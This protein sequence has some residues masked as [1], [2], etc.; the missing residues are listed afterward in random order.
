MTVESLI[1]RLDG[2]V[3]NDTI[4][5]PTD[6]YMV[7]GIKPRIV[8]VP[9]DL[10]ELR[11]IMQLVNEYKASV[12]P[13]IRGTKLFIGNIPKSYDAALDLGRVA[14][15]VKADPEE[16][17]A[18]IGVSV[19]FMDAQNEL[20]RVG[21]R[22]PMDPLLSSISSIG[23][24]MALNLY[25][26]MAHRLLT[27]R[28]LVLRVRA[29][30]PGGHVVKWGT[31]MIKDV[32]GYNLKRV[33]IGSMG[34]LGVIYEVN[35]RLLAVPEVEAVVSIR[36][37]MDLRS[38][39]RFMGM[40]YISINGMTYIRL[41]GVKEEVEYRISSIKGEVYYGRE[42]YEL[43][44]RVTS[45]DELFDN[46]PVILKIITPPAQLGNIIGL[47]N[48]YLVTLPM[49]GIAYVGVSSID[50]KTISNVRE[51]ATKVGGYVVVLKAPLDIKRGI[52]VWGVTTNVDL[53][54]KLKGVFDP[55]GIMNP[56]RF[57]G[58]I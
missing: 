57:V 56:G 1:N 14:N 41:E 6:K 28:D 36:E 46:Y 13:T 54:S 52:D 44:Y 4:E 34:T 19:S 29:V 47:I 20:T 12:I 58:G 53:M 55:S 7:D 43:W 27:T 17:V 48:G 32:A 45:M 30:L 51:E 42:A 50:V 2:L 9:R 24:V 5:E 15:Y 16:M 18:D 35:T 40:G 8:L 25:G 21:R 39:R 37:P 22:L 11:T 3:S 49:L 23:G 33:F 38:L 26:P 10:E 31:G